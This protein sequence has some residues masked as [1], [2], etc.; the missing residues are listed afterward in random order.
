M[1]L[2]LHGIPLDTLRQVTAVVMATDIL[3]FKLLQVGIGCHGYC[4]CHI[5][6]RYHFHL[7]TGTQPDVLY[8]AYVLPI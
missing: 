4:D 5:I 1:F 3:A 8:V 6:V 2:P 7:S